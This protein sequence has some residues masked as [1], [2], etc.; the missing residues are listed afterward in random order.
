M[1]EN[2]SDRIRTTLLS[3]SM[4]VTQLSEAID[5]PPA[6]L[7]AEL[8]RLATSGRVH[9]LG[10]AEYPIWTGRIGEQISEGELVEA[11]TRLLAEQPMTTRDLADA[12]GA[13]LRRVG[14]AIRAIRRGPDRARLFD[15][16]VDGDA[17]RWFLLP[18]GARPARL[19]SP[20][21]AAAPRSW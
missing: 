16:G 17:A 21:P 11:M 5:A 20:G 10:S 13:D 9:N 3:I 19:I 18:R 1:H 12:T 14:L 2:I 7:Q 4:D 8:K 15:L 6:E